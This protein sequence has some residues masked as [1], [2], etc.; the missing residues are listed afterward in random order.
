[1]HG[2]GTLSFPMLLQV[3]N[4]IPK[5]WVS[6]FVSCIE[7]LRDWFKLH[8]ERSCGPAL[9]TM[10]RYP[11]TARLEFFFLTWS[12]LGC[13]QPVSVSICQQWQGRWLPADQGSCICSKEGRRS[14]APACVNRTSVEWR[15]FSSSFLLSFELPHT[16]KTKFSSISWY[17]HPTTLR[18]RVI[19]V[20]LYLDFSPS[21]SCLSKSPTTILTSIE[22][23]ETT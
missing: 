8:R 5:I 2:V 19:P 9:S 15:L 20:S 17:D 13:H 22:Q 23:Q 6:G 21:S 12:C 1:M 14:N 16:R 10:Y 7:S 4:S 3:S 18:W 11:D